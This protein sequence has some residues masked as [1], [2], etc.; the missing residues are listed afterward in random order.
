LS[1]SATSAQGCSSIAQATI[2]V[3]E[4]PQFSITGDNSPCGNTTF[5]LFAD[6]ASLSYEWFLNNN[7]SISTSD[8]LVYEGTYDQIAFYV[9]GIDTITQCQNTQ[10]ITGQAIAGP[11]SSLPALSEFCEDQNALI[12]DESGFEIT[13]QITGNEIEPDTFVGPVLNFP[14]EVGSYNVFATIRD[15][16]ENCTSYDTLNVIIH[17]NP[18]F[19][20]NNTSVT[21]A[22]QP[23]E[24]LIS[25]VA[26][27]GSITPNY[28]VNWI[29]NNGFLSD[30]NPFIENSASAGNYLISAVV[31]ESAHNCSATDTLE[32]TVTTGPSFVHPRASE[33]CFGENVLLTIDS[34]NTADYSVLWTF[35]ESTTEGNS[36][37]L[38]LNDSITTYTVS[39]SNNVTGCITDS[40][41]YVEALPLPSAFEI[42]LLTNGLLAIETD[43]NNGLT[44]GYTS[45]ATGIEIIIGATDNYAYFENF[46]P[47][48]NYYWAEYANTNGCVLRVYF[49][50][51]LNIE[52]PSADA[53]V[54]YPI[55]VS[56][57]LN[58]ESDSFRQSSTF[59]F[60]IMG[61]LG[62]VLEQGI[63]QSNHNRITLDI[64]KLSAGQY[65]IVLHT[66]AT[67]LCFAFTK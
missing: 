63:A 2:F 36:A 11:L 1:V 52:T 15:T 66:H 43:N 51:P 48:N 47:A 28:T 35:P 49:N 4:L 37:T 27:G 19:V 57:Q 45:A 33:T 50:Q 67:H 17:A 61:S 23:I 25:D 24:F 58:I 29:N 21:C 55:P 32:V 3:N 30:E 42:S 54:A 20:M 26:V 7:I 6:N 62:Q 41:Y 31:T 9:T 5:E 65:Y 13:W 46:D 40:T 22:N 38:A 44:W 16:S 14:L 64:S 39:L 59:T 34:V 12:S 56:D 53:F 18:V 10:E 8:S 60:S